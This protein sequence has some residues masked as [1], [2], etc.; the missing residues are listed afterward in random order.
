MAAL[1]RAGLQ[2][3][4]NI[5]Q[6]SQYRNASHDA[7]HQ[8]VNE[9]FGL[10]FYLAVGAIPFSYAVYSLSR[11]DG[12]NVPWLTGFI[13]SYDHWRAQWE[14]RNELHT[15]M[16]EQAGA[17]R[18]LF[19]GSRTPEMSRPVDIKFQEMFNTGSPFNVPAGQGSVNLDKVM[20]HYKTQNAL[21][22]KERINR[23]HAH[24]S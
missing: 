11:A 15:K 24:D 3:S 22:E 4:R 19:F 20:E 18:L 6:R 12:E 8:P 2:S 7:H 13:H 21:Q 16:V 23:A 1:R 10:G 5:L 17:D 9:S 14:R